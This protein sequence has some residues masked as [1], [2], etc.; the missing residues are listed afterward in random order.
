[1]VATKPLTADDLLTIPGDY[2]LI[3]GELRE[4]SPSSAEPTMVALNVGS[5][6]HLFVGQHKLGLVT[7][8]DGGFNLFPDR[9]TVVAP[10]VGFIRRGRIPPDFDFQHYF[11]V[12]PDLAFEAVSPSD[13]FSEVM[14]KVELYLEAGVR[15]VWVAIPQRRVV[16]VYR[17]DRAPKTLTE[18]DELDGED[19]VPGF[20]MS[21]RAVFANPLAG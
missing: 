10:D 7:G 12:P 5:P 11:P 4:V 21:V 6:L 1:M 3:R 14:E 13:S 16:V 19:V 20:R 2:E 15:L 17:L 8:A 9:R 18:N